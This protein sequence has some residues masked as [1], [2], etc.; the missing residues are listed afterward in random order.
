MEKE[1]RKSAAR[2]PNALKR[3]LNAAQ[4]ATL[5]DLERFGWELKFVRRPLFRE[6]VAV[7]F[8]ADRSHFAVL[9]ADGTLNENP[10]FDIRH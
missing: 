6:P 3:E 1:R 5:V 7:V 4:Q 2:I 9:Q 10:G 8:D